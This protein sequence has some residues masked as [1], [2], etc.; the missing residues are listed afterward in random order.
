MRW[1]MA[2]PC[3][4]RMFPLRRP[5]WPNMVPVEKSEE[6]ASEAAKEIGNQ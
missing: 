6:Q 1:E 4:R 3:I 5:Y 2:A